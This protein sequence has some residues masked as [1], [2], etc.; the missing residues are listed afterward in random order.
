VL[1]A[2][3]PLIDL[4]LRRRAEALTN[5]TLRPASRVTLDA[6]QAEPL[7]RRSADGC[8]SSNKPKRSTTG[9]P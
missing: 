9:S 5:I 3:R 6:T 1:C 7:S 8:P 2:T 4:V